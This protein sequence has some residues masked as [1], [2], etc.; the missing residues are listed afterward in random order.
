M[1]TASASYEILDMLNVETHY[2][3]TFM[4]ADGNA[5]DLYNWYI[6]ICCENQLFI[7]PDFFKAMTD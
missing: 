7:A 4:T 5:T 6:N 3:E 2:M 1:Q